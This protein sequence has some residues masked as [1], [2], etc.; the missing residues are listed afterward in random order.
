MD[1]YRRFREAVL[2][3]ILLALPFFFL[4][5]NLKNPNQA[6]WLD[7]IVLQ[8]SMPMHYVATLAARGVSEAL[9]KYTYR[10]H[11]EHAYKALS[12]ENAR[13]T[14]RLRQSE[15][16][17]SENRRLRDLLGL[18]E[19]LRQQ[20]LTAM[21]IGKEVSPFFRVVRLR[22][23]KGS[24]QGV[25]MGLPVVSADGLVGQIRRSAVAKHYSEVLLTVDRTSA[26]D[27][28][29]ESTGARGILRGTGEGDRYRCRLEYLQRKDRV[30][31]G[32]A[33]STSG[34]GQR[35]PKG[36]LVGH[37]SK[38]NRRSAGLHQEAEVR[39]SVDFSRLQE[40]LILVGSSRQRGSADDLGVAPTSVEP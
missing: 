6:D 35:F 24:E 31:V 10:L 27:I 18:Q 11:V 33:L 25:R 23:D 4:R 29:A 34:F 19:R 1:H 12:Q 13:L 36:I 37:I 28:V 16:I 26:V 17:R 22:L 9:G 14:Q 3:V 40:A 30:N 21:V 2:C 15:T 39:P 8:V 32:D 38:V 20:T 5:S 7:R